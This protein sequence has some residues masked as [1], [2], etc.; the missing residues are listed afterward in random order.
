M[1]ALQPLFVPLNGSNTNMFQSMTLRP[2]HNFTYVQWR[3][4]ALSISILISISAY[5]YVYAYIHTYVYV[6][7]RGPRCFLM[8]YL[9]T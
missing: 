8:C 6:Y 1:L 7:V 5:I 4:I 2:C 3:L 9:D